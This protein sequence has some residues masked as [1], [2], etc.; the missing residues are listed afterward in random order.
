MRC[1]DTGDSLGSL[2]HSEP[3]KWLRWDRIGNAPFVTVNFK[4]RSLGK[5]TYSAMSL[6]TH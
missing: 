1:A 3:V 2:V 4:Y 5:P 6:T